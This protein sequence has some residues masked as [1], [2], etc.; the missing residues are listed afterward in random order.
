MT[1]EVKESLSLLKENLNKGKKNVGILREKFDETTYTIVHSYSEYV[2]QISKETFLYLI[3]NNY[4]NFRQQT[5]IGCHWFYEFTKDTERGFSLYSLYSL[6][7]FSFLKNKKFYIVPR[8]KSNVYFVE[9]DECNFTKNKKHATLLTL[10]EFFY[11]YCNR[12][13]GFMYKTF[14]DNYTHI[15][16]YGSNHIYTSQNSDKDVEQ[17]NGEIKY[18]EKYVKNFDILTEDKKDRY[19]INFSFEQVDRDLAPLDNSYHN[20]LIDKQNSI[21]N[22]K[23]N[24]FV[25]FSI[26]TRS[27]DLFS[28]RHLY[29]NASYIRFTDK[30]PIERE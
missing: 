3:Q 18:C 9:S 14:C 8:G 7:D 19:K 13:N 28:T 20:Y 17:K 27:R 16:F 25:T 4:L 15:G 11:V 1:N 12:R 23:N 2:K 5:K 22:D 21:L 24:F 6:E 10:N 29:Y 30:K 26:K